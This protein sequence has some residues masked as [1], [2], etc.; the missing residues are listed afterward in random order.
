MIKRDPEP[1]TD[2]PSKDPYDGKLSLASTL[3]K[4]FPYDDADGNLDDFAPFYKEKKS[5]ADA[6]VVGKLNGE[7]VT[8]QS[9]INLI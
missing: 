8:R 7:N 2:A 5:L 3:D 1:K 4:G 9:L 6:T